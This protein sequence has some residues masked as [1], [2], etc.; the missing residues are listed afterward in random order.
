V[1]LG[2][3]LNEIASG[4]TDNN[5]WQLD[6]TTAKITSLSPGRNDLANNEHNCKLAAYETWLNKLES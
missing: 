1:S 3:A 5:R 2:K 4:K 6:S